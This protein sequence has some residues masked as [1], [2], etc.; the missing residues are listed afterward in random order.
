MHLYAIYLIYLV[1]RCF[2]YVFHHLLHSPFRAHRIRTAWAQMRSFDLGMIL[3]H[4]SSK[5]YYNSM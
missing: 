4:V 3:S 5:F 1:P 2:Y